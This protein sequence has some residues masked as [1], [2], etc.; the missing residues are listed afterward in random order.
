MKTFKNDF[1]SFKTHLQ[2]YTQKNNTEIEKKNKKLLY[3]DNT[4][5]KLYFSNETGK[6]VQMQDKIFE[7]FF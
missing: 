5:A 2:N 1:Q 4:I 7:K 6:K 3:K